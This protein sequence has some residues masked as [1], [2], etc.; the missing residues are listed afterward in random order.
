MNLWDIQILVSLAS[1]VACCLALLH[2]WQAWARPMRRLTDLTRDIRSGRVAIDELAQIRGGVRPIVPVI[3]ELLRELKQQKK[4]LTALNQEMQERVAGRTDAL[5]RK[6]GSLQV[7]AT[8]DPLTGLFNRRSLEQE[9]G[10]IV[11]RYARGEP[12]ACLL[13]A[14]VD[15]FKQL[16]DTLGHAAGDQL[17][18]E[19]GQIIRSSISESDMAFR[20]GGDEFVIL[21]DGCTFA[22]GAAKAERIV[23]LVKALTRSMRVGVPPG[24]SV[25]ACGIEEVDGAAAG[26]WMEMTDKRLY[27][28]KARRKAGSGKP[29]SRPLVPSPL[30][31]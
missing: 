3:Q 9:L 27:Q 7:Q 8:R 28:V 1:A 24:L 16:N 22:E 4:Q 30:R 12:G 25:G 2:W 20:L 21:L 26:H 10:R 29:I 18:R 23:S 6:I 5:E 15:H 11:A 31:P 17:L 13:M 14:D 19:I